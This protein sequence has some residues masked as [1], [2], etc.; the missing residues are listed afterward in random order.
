MSTPFGKRGAF[1]EAWERGGPG[2][3]R[4]RVTAEECPRISK[5]FL[6]EERASMGER[7]F[8]QEYLCEFVDVMSCVFDRDI[9]ESAMTDE[10]EPL[11]ITGAAPWE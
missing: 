11:Q 3:E 2:W 8:R 1:W 7:W 10:I 6:A 4:V 9:I 5:E